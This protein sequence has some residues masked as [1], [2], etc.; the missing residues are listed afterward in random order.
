MLVT[1]ER[2]CQPKVFL[3]C[4]R[5]RPLSPGRTHTSWKL[6]RCASAGA[7]ERGDLD[8]HDVSGITTRARIDDVRARFAGVERHAGAT[9]R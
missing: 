4:Q 6:V 1:T 7:H 5:W 3:R 9:V 8:E 2:S